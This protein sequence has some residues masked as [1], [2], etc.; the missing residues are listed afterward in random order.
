MES[1][2]WFLSKTL[3]FNVLAVSLYVAVAVAGPFGYEGSIP[4]DVK[5]YVDVFVPAVVA[6]INLGLRFFATKQ[7]LE[8]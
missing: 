7:P 8:L 3:W 5:G 2:K 6:L 1:K 4:E